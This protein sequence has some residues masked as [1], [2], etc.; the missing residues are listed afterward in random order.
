MLFFFNFFQLTCYRRPKLML[1]YVQLNLWSSC[2][3]ICFVQCKRN[4]FTGEVTNMVNNYLYFQKKNHTEKFSLLRLGRAFEQFIL[5]VNNM[6]HQSHFKTLQSKFDSS[7]CIFSWKNNK[8]IGNNK[9]TELCANNLFN[10]LCKEDL[11]TSWPLSL[12]PWHSCQD[13]YLTFEQYCTSTEGAS[14]SSHYSEWI[15]P[16]WMITLEIFPLFPLQIT[17]LVIDILFHLCDL[18]HR[19]G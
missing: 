11:Q 6:F 12:H 1:R 17:P 13:C 7:L 9:Y 4:F 5:E 15:L 2:A 18:E 3:S 14:V 10:S 16:F 19:R 8:K